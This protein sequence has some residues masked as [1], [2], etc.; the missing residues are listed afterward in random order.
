MSRGFRAKAAG[1][2]VGILSLTQAHAAE[3]KKAGEA[4]GPVTPDVEV[5][6]DSQQ[7]WIESQIEALDPDGRSAPDPDGS[8]GAPATGCGAAPL[9]PLLGPLGRRRRRAAVETPT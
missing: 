6:V 1:T 9:F 2:L 8:A 7:S 3:P 5:R 4:K